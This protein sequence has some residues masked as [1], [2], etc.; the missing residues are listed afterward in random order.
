MGE[1]TTQ[2]FFGRTI[3]RFRDSAPWASS[4]L[5]WLTPSVVEQA[6]AD[7]FAEPQRPAHPA[8]PY[9]P[10]IEGHRFRVF[11]RG[12]ELAVW[13]WGEGPTVLL[14]HGWN[15]QAAQMAGFVQPLVS[16][17]YHVV[18]FDHLGHGASQGTRATILDFAEAVRAVAER[19]QSVH[20]IIAHSLGATAT[21]LALARGLT[22]ERAVLLAPPAE[23]A[24]FARA[25]AATLGLPAPRIEG[26]LDRVRRELGG[27]LD[28]LDL[29]VIGPRVRTPL[30]VLHDAQDRSVPFVHGKAVADAAPNARLVRMSGVGHAGL[31]VNRQ[32][33]SKAVEFVGTPRSPLMQLPSAPSTPKARKSA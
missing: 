25:F 4:A 2:G 1:R 23:V 18:A 21:V 13:D 17:G 8:E 32:V 29:R 16:A 7:R 33:I 19:V 14:V 31:L 30:L 27:D 10:G 9:V 22:A 15:G 26:M 24:P 28:A 12:Q 3:G 20:A 5:A 6:A 11:V